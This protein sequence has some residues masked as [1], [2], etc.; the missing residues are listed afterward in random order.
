MLDLVFKR[1]FM[2]SIVLL[3]VF[4]VGG[5]EPIAKKYATHHIDANYVVG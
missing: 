5:T 1:V 4:A 3:A 2:V